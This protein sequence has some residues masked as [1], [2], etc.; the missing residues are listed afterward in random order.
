MRAT[1]PCPGCGSSHV[2][3][4]RTG[5]RAGTRANRE[6]GAEEKVRYVEHGGVMSNQVMSGGDLFYGGG[7][8]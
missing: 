7:T 4:R 5:V 3:R 1:V 2:E 8:Y 6:I